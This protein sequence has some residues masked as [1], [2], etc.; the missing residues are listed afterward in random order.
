MI[1]LSENAG[2]AMTSIKGRGDIEACIYK[3]RKTRTKQ[4]YE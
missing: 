1:D 3:R 4:Q 2:T